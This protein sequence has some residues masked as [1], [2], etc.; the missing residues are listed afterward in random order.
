MT[1]VAIYCL[2]TNLLRLEIRN[3]MFSAFWYPGLVSRF[4]S[5]ALN[6]YRLQSDEQVSTTGHVDNM[7]LL[8]FIQNKHSHR[9]YHHHQRTELLIT[10]LLLI[11]R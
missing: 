5:P 11:K 6:V 1:L 3:Q 10:T 4:Q 8:V 2:S 9:A 7:L